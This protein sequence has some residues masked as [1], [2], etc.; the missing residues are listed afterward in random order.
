[1]RTVRYRLTS[2]RPSVDLPASEIRSD[3]D[4]WGG[5]ALFCAF[6]GLLILVP[7]VFL[8]GTNVEYGYGAGIFFVLFS[9]F[10]GWLWK[11]NGYLICRIDEHGITSFYLKANRL[12]H[13]GEI[14]SCEVVY[15]LVGPKVQEQCRFLNKDQQAIGSVGL[16]DASAKQRTLFLNQ[17]E[18]WFAER[19][20][21]I[22]PE[23]ETT[24]EPTPTPQH[25]VESQNTNNIQRVGKR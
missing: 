15:N 12:M 16:Q 7:V 20:N 23:T 14:A 9:L 18:C 8:G 13:W 1:M 22:A 5:L 24:E 17:L 10:F 6:F 11:K 2:P 19:S 25:I 4:V 3:R 21:G